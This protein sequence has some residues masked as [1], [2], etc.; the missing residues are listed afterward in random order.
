MV[1]STIWYKAVKKRNSP[2]YYSTVMKSTVLNRK[3]KNS[4][5]P[6]RTE[7]DRTLHIFTEQ[8]RTVNPTTA[9]NNAL[10]TNIKEEIPQSSARTIIK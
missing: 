5:E 8:Y 10:V 4:T 1:R 9:P 6:Y 3:V 2:E 7:Q